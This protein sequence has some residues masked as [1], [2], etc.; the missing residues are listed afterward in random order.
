MTVHIPKDASGG[1]I[2]NAQETWTYSFDKILHNASQEDVFQ[3]C[4][5]E[6]VRKVPDGYNGTIMAYGQT[7]AGKT[8]T[9]NGSTPNFK[10]RGLIPRA[11]NLIFQEIGSKHDHDIVVKVS[12][13]EIYNEQIYDLLSDERRDSQ[14]G[15]AISIQDD[16]KGEVHVKGLQCLHARNEEEAL[17][18]LF[19]GETRKTL[20]AT[21]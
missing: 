1:F 17:N 11:I 16:A 8:F 14:A 19:E 9:M 2:N 4:G 21:Q 18:I 6:I 13:L 5:E 10:Y 15:S 7:G 3:Y 20:A 12:F